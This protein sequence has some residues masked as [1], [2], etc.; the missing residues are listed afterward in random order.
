MGMGG[1]SALALEGLS[2][3]N[4]TPT[5]MSGGPRWVLMDRSCGVYFCF[6]SA[7]W[8]IWLPMSPLSRVHKLGVV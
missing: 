1:V 6:L 5:A 3:R 7:A 8:L 2:V 4:L